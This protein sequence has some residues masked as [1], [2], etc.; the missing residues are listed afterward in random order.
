[1]YCIHRKKKS[2]HYDTVKALFFLSKEIVKR[3][4]KSILY[5]HKLLLD[6]MTLCK[7]QNF[8]LKMGESSMNIKEEKRVGKFVE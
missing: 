6:I 7:K 3:G 4:S 5:R 8:Q 1:M 2:F